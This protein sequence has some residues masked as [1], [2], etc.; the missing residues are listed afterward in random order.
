[1]KMCVYALIS[2]LS[3]LLLST[4]AYSD[5][6]PHPSLASDQ[7]DDALMNFQRSILESRHR[8]NA[9]APEVT[10]ENVATYPI[11]AAA[12]VQH[13]SRD[14]PL[15]MNYILN[16]SVNVPRNAE[17]GSISVQKGTI[18]LSP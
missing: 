14:T 11:P 2:I 9:T 18:I 16:H 6:I 15:S 13:V 17:A 1:M 8:R 5:E 4:Y 12:I 10:M 3:S 7:A